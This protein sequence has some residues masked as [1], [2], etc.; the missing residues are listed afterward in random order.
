MFRKF[1][2]QPWYLFRYMLV[3]TLVLGALSALYGM[4]ARFYLLVGVGHSPAL[5]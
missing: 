1:R 3:W 5:R 2:D 4:P